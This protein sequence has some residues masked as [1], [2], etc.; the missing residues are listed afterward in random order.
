M[1]DIKKGTVKFFN[2]EKGFGFIAQDS[3]DDMFFHFSELGDEFKKTAS[4]GQL[5]TYVI[6]DG[7]DGKEVA[8]RVELAR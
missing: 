7:R 3:G 5:V 8:N 6:G 4:F 2:E 1:A